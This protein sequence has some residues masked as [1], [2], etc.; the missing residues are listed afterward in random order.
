MRTAIIRAEGV[1]LGEERVRQYHPREGVRGA[2]PSSAPKAR[3][4]PL[5]TMAPRSYRSGA[6]RAS[7]W[8]R[9]SK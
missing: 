1:L 7:L 2:V 5:R 3:M 8:R 9:Y 4:A 6:M